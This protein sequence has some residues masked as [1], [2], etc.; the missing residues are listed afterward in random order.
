[1]KHIVYSPIEY[2]N[3]LAANLANAFMNCEESIALRIVLSWA[4]DVT[5]KTSHGHVFASSW[6]NVPGSV[7]NDCWRSPL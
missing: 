5:A 4:A 7:L 6:R 2:S 1:M 3:P